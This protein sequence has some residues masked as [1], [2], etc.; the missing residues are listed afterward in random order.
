[1]ILI[2][3]MN[4]EK[5]SLGTYEFV[6]PIA[7]IVKDFEAYA[8][9][10]YSELS[11]ADVDKCSRVILSGNALRNRQTL[12]RTEDFNWIKKCE[13]PM[14]GI[15][16]G[17]QAIGLV[18]GSSLKRCLEIGMKQVTTVRENPLFSSSFKAYELHRYSIQPSNELVVLAESKRCVQAMKHKKKDAYGVLFHPEVRNREIVE[19]FAGLPT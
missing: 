1:M 9:R 8:I 7:S 14:L 17:M 2:V 13:K 10:H 19:K 6:L 15:C 5:D 4:S 11:Q 3:D 16:A 18:F 12:A